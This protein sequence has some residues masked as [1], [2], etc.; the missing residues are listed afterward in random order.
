MEREEVRWQMWW[1]L[2]AV[3]TEGEGGRLGDRKEVT[4]GSSRRSERGR[5]NLVGKSMRDECE[6]K[7]KAPPKRSSEEEMGVY[8]LSAELRRRW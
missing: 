7:R 3:T 6:A 1:M 8:R 5:R 2:R 4:K